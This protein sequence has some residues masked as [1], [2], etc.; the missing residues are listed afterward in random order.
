MLKQLDLTCP[1]RHD[2]LLS[3]FL[4]ASK[5]NLEFLFLHFRGNCVAFG[6]FPLRDVEHFHPGRSTDPYTHLKDVTLVYENVN[7]EPMDY[8]LYWTR[9]AWVEGILRHFGQSFLGGSLPP[10]NTVTVRMDLRYVFN[11]DE[12][13]PYKPEHDPEFLPL[14]HTARDHLFRCVREGEILLPLHGRHTRFHRASDGT[15]TEETISSDYR[16]KRPSDDW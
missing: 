9:M 10:D 15:I 14:I 4:D 2:R 12:N 8:W 5:E 7:P 13:P 6:T 3:R 11:N 16:L 1:E